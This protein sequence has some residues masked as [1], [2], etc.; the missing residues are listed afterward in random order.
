M[1]AQASKIELARIILGLENPDLIAKIKG[2]V[3]KETEDFWLELTA[4][5]KEEIEL[6]I[7]LLDEG[8]RIPFE[9]TLKKLG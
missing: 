1:D 3:L 4:T 8:R 7:R 2:F 5:E 6:G 9:E